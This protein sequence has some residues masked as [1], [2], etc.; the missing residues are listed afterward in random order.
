MS[1]LIFPAILVT[2]FYI[3]EKRFEKKMEKKYGPTPQWLKD[4]YGWDD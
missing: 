2:I 4:K 1:W 3:N